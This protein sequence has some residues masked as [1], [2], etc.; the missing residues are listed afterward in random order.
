MSGRTTLFFDIGG[1]LLTNGWDTAA[2]KRVAARFEIDY[3]EFQTRHEMLKTA[4]ETGRLSL[5][6]YVRK[7][8]FHRRRDF[9]PEDFK[10]AMFDSS[11]RLGDTLEF[12][13]ALSR[14]GNCRLYT[15]N[16]ESRELHEHRVAAFGLDQIFRGFLTSC[17]L[18]QVKPD[19]AIY[20]NALGIAA[21]R[22]EDAIFIDDRALNVEPALAMGLVAHQFTGLE[23]LRAFLADR[24][25]GA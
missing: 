19:E 24:G 14:A 3:P 9:H 4:F 8:V 22:P 12:V 16:N 21:C 15:L 5:D 10:R 1:V 20:S 7:A 25:V 17:Y 18:G 13:H 23:E 2:R 6:A 11:E